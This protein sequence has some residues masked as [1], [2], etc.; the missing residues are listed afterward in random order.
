MKNLI[1]V[2]TVVFGL[3]LCSSGLAIEL[4][5]KAGFGLKVSSGGVPKGTFKV[6]LTDRDAFEAEGG[7]SSLGW[8]VGG[9]YAN[10]FMKI[11]SLTPYFC[12][13]A[14]VTG[15]GNAVV[16][17]ISAGVGLE[18]FANKNLSFFAEDRASILIAGG[19]AFVAGIDTGFRY[20]F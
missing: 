4:N 15:F 16:F 13:G 1:W 2:V 5:G 17:A 6:F 10:H 14:G 3:M 19:A 7:I 9:Q 20:Y 11:G 18:Y 12:A 8:L